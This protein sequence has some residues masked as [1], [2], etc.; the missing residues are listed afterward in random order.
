LKVKTRKIDI[1]RYKFK[2]PTPYQY[3]QTIAPQHEI[4]PITPEITKSLPQPTTYEKGKPVTPAIQNIYFPLPSYSFQTWI[5]VVVGWEF[6]E[7][8]IIPAGTTETIFTGLDGDTDEFYMLIGDLL[9]NGGGTDI[10]VY[11]AP[12]GIETGQQ[13]LGAQLYNN[14]GTVGEYYLVN[15]KTSCLPLAVNGWTENGWCSFLAILHA[16]ANK[17]RYSN[18]HLVWR[19][20]V[21]NRIS[22]VDWNWIWDDQT[23][24]ITSLVVRTSGGSFEGTLRLYRLKK[25]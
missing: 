20:D 4:K 23:T 8:K 17:K 10:T 19:S 2:L 22:T 9:L 24:K 15:W 18:T 6:I 7:E 13:N 1:L 25:T 14:L 5:V 3:K 12:N 16:K 21:A 11:V